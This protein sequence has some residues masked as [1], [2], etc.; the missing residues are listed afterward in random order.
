MTVKLGGVCAFKSFLN[1]LTFKT[2]GV[3]AS[4]APYLKA[5][6]A[7][8]YM[9]HDQ[10][11]DGIGNGTARWIIDSDLPSTDRTR[12]L[13]QDGAC[14]Y[15]ARIDS[16]NISGPPVDGDWIVFCGNGWQT[17]NLMVDVHAGEHPV[18]ANGTTPAHLVNFAL[19]GKFCAGKEFF[20]GLE[21]DVAGVTNSSAAFFKSREH[22]QYMY[23]DPSCSGAPDGKARWVI[24]DEKPMRDAVSDLDGDSACNYHARVDSGDTSSPPKAAMWRLHCDGAWEDIW[25]TL[26][27][28]SP[29]L[30]TEVPTTTD[31]PPQP[32]STTAVA[33]TTEEGKGT[34]D[35]V[36]GLRWH[37]ATPLV[38]VVAM[39]LARENLQ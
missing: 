1:G 32:E 10:D 39:I 5:V 28:I 14:N 34:V 21:F 8:Q 19:S 17:Q 2:Q 24:D 7:D 18:E 37:L 27:D 26:D 30:A 4:G 29:E 38:S 6:G 20:Q 13:D 25:I 15:H 11:C 23:Y 33:N 12:D 22:G 9:Y 36:H 3:T 16:S 31:S 35:G